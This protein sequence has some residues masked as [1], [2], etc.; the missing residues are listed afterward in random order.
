MT[1]VKRKYAWR[2]DVADH[3]DHLYTPQL[4]HV[5][6]KVD[7][8]GASVAIDDQGQLGS[9]TGNS[10]TAMCEIILKTVPLSR[11]MA[12]YG[13]RAREGTTK[14]DAGAQIRD[15]IA[16]IS[17]YGVCEESL[18]P[19]DITKF[20]L[21][22][23]KV[24]Y[25]DGATRVKPLVLNYQ[26]V[27]DLPTLKAA[28]AVGHVVTFGFSV[29]SYFES[30]QVATTGWVRMPTQADQIIGGHAVVAVGYDDTASVPFVW[31]RNSWGPAWGLNGYFKMDQKWF[32]DPSGLVDD[33][34]TVVP[35]A[36]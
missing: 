30:Q 15:V 28:L 3:R 7:I 27:T 19:Y 34:W 8:I 16:G 6:P 13:G 1:D 36:A 23:P 35:K 24:A 26:R 21:K 10:S 12:Y 31:V 22:P 14:Q 32:T 18:W 9:C 33:M 4:S 5:P 11:L 17:N 20:A 29:P 2:P 25:N